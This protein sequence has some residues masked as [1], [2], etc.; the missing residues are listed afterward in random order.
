MARVQLMASCTVQVQAFVLDQTTFCLYG[1]DKNQVTQVASNI[2]RIRPPE[3]YKGA[4]IRIVGESIK[5][6][7]RRVK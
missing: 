6:K 1:V 5:I 7:D 3:P 2:R 4:G